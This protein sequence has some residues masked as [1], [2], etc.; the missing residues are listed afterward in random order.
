M[1]F[2]KKS[3]T[4]IGPK[5]YGEGDFEFLD[6]SGRREA[7]NVRKFLSSWLGKFPEGEQSELISRIQSRD[8][9]AYESATFEIILYA[10]LTN[11]GASIEI[12]PELDNGS[13]K[14]PDFLV[15][16]SKGEEFYVEAVLASEHSGA[17]LAAERRKNVVLD[18]IERLESPN[19]F[20]GINAEGNPE[21]PPSGKAL[22]REISNWLA[23]L[24]PDDVTNAVDEHGFEAV[25]KLQWCHDGWEIEFEAIPKNPEKR[26]SV[27]RVIGVLSGEARFINGWEPIR[28]ALRSKGNRYGELTKPLVIAV[29][30]DAFSLDRID[31]MQALFGEEEYVFSRD[32]PDTQPAMQRAANGLWNGPQGPQY[33]RISGAWLFGGINPW[34]VVSRKNTVYFNPW[35]RL[36]APEELQRLTHASAREEKMEWL[37]GISL[38][39]LLKLDSS[40][41][42]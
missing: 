6:R 42:E 4:Y 8:P 3:R 26:G 25:P 11:L 20:L 15:S 29:N 35:A 14:H 40:W 17:E 12:H 27:E 13:D 41:P 31:E 34:N 2:E 16:F 18:S 21:T 33:T 5:S 7:E 19:F 39:R 36:A 1:L 22:R 28:D 38:A 24:D 23:K 32:N 9:K 37:D 10:I 30:V